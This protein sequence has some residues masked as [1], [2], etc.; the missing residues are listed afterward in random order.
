MTELS[1]FCRLNKLENEKNV[2]KASNEKLKKQMSEELAEFKNGYFYLYV[3][4]MY[5]Y[6]CTFVYI[7]MYVPIT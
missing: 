1:F 7:C 5:A 6:I 4:Y 2:L 3:H